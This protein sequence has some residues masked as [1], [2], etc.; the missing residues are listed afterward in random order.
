MKIDHIEVRNFLSSRD[1]GKEENK[2]RAVFVEFVK[3]CR[4]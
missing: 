2:I 3:F 4:R 1:F